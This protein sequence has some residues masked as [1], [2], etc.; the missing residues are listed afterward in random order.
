M[1]LRKWE[2]EKG[3]LAMVLPKYVPKK[4]QLAFLK[5][6]T[7]LIEIFFFKKNLNCGKSND[8]ATNYFIIFLQIV[9]MTNFL[10]VLIRATNNI[11]FYL[12]ISTYH[13]SSL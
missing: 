1:M 12:L 3:I 10:L 7:D 9:V 8:T 2:R 11:T 13:I 4:T 5:L 6:E